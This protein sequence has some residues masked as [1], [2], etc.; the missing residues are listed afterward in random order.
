MAECAHDARPAS[1]TY[2]KSY[3]Q[4][5]RILVVQEENQ[6]GETALILDYHL[7]VLRLRGQVPQLTH[8]RQRIHHL[9]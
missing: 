3:E 1:I 7:S 4:H 5:V 6:P 8:Y 9:R 2:L